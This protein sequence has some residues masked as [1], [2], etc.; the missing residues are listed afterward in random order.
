MPLTFDQ[1]TTLGSRAVGSPPLVYIVLNITGNTP[2]KYY[3][4]TSVER[5]RTVGT[6]SVPGIRTGQNV[7]RSQ[8]AVGDTVSSGDKQRADYNYAERAVKSNVTCSKITSI[9]V[10]RR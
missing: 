2:E 10:A 1:R 9:P 7:L 6:E 8:Y 3:F 4:P 5:Y